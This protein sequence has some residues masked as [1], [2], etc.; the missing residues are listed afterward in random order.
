MLLTAAS[1]GKKTPALPD[2]AYK[3]A[4]TIIHM[5]QNEAVRLKLN[6]AR[7]SLFRTCYLTKSEDLAKKM[8]ANAFI[9][10]GLD[11]I[12]LRCY[13]QNE[14]ME[15]GDKNPP[16]EKFPQDVLDSYRAAMEQ[17]FTVIPFYTLKHEGCASISG[18]EHKAKFDTELHTHF[19]ERRVLMEASTWY[20]EAQNKILDMVFTQAK[21]MQI[22][23]GGQCHDNV[24]RFCENYFRSVSGMCHFKKSSKDGTTTKDDRGRLLCSMKI[25]Y[26]SELDDTPAATAAPY[27]VNLLEELAATE[28]LQV[29]KKE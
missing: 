19:R 14:A 2:Y 10:P 11:W 25:L 21:Q 12:S 23:I 20:R 15:Y 6:S 9:I 4:D 1:A 13:Y 16:V 18:A 17:L 22:V 7:F 29:V 5:D 3:M 24:C 28:E 8:F 27:Q 26:N